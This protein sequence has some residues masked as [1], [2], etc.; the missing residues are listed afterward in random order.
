MLTILEKIGFRL[1]FIA[2]DRDTKI[3]QLKLK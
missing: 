3:Y 1:T 2:D